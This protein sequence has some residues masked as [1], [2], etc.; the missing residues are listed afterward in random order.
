MSLRNKYHWKKILP[1]VAG[2]LLLLFPFVIRNAYYQRIVTISAIYILLAS[3]LNLLIGYLGLFSLGHAAFYCIGAYTSAL[4]ATRLHVPF[5]FCMFA[6]GIAA[7]LVGALIGSITL[8]L[9]DIFLA[10]ATLGL[11][12]VI[13]I[14][15]LNQ[16][17]FTGGPMGV[18]GIPAPKFFGKP[19]TSTM[20]YY[21]AIF[22]VILVLFVI[23]RLV[24]SNTGRALMSI[25][26][27]EPAAKSLGVNTY[28]YKLLTM[29]ISCFI[30]GIAG[31][32]Y[33]HFVRFISADTFNFNESINM[34]AMVAIGGMGTVVGPVVGA[35]VLTIMPE[36]FRFLASYR[37]LLY[38]AALVCAIVFAPKG[39]VGI[40]F[41]S[42][43]NKWIL[44]PLSIRKGKKKGVVH[45]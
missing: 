12:E 34:V 32:F 9:S 7:G 26:E 19:F 22:L 14:L 31:S 45:D 33:A 6:G 16:V 41:C 40:P 18:V 27:D 21:L 4:L 10:F 13:R 15:I 25:R 28:Y 2:L 23:N 11:S 42:L 38:G 44:N 8:R 29:I 30:A 20:Y 17:K 1:I 3:S 5:I 35:I 39:I 24:N 36:I 43:L 37:Q